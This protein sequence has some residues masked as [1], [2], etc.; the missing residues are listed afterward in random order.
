MKVL[1][2][3]CFSG[4]SGDMN[5]GAM[6]D[7]GVSAEMLRS[8]LKKLKIGGWDL[9]VTKDQRHGITGTKVTVATEA[10]GHDHHDGHNQDHHHNHSH[11][12]HLD[13]IEEI[14]NESDLSPAVKS[15]AMKIFHHIAEAEAAVHNVPIEK[16]HF[17]EVGAVDSIIDI[18]GAA[19]CYEALGV[20]KVYVTPVELGSG[21][22]RCEHGVLPVPAPATERIIRGFPVHRGGVDFE[23]TTPTGA[24]IIAAF[25]EPETADMNFTITNTGYGIGHK[26]NPALPNILRVFL[27]ETSAVNTNRSN[28]FVVE[29]NIDDMNPE[30]T[31]Y[32][33][34]RLFSAGAGDVYITPIIMKKGR[35]AITISIICEEEH[36]SEIKK[37][38]FTESTTIGLRVF[39][40]RKETLRRETGEIDTPFG[41][42]VVKKSFLESKLV[43]VKPEAD[44]CA[45]IAAREGI[46]MKQVMQVIINYL[47]GKK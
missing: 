11:H 4:I 40:F 37:I 15:L 47:E 38:L 25:A 6:I 32:V 16:I 27:A 39:P 23:A 19:V 22:V 8:E 5:L 46:P 44:Q 28:S 9:V 35:P 45:A 36:L 43:S 14:I 31:D 10:E 42:V 34:S 41:K 24:A 1:F 26:D 7:L 33:T 17:H 29:C 2:Y 21:T 18:T 3:D 20:D 30:L 13:D 12:R